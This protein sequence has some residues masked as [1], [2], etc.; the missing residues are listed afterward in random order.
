MSGRKADIVQVACGSVFL[1]THF[2]ALP[3]VVP[4]TKPAPLVYI[5]YLCPWTFQVF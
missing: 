2:F 1:G 4:L 3:L 5:V